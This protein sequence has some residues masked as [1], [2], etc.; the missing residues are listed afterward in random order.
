MGTFQVNI[1]IRNVISAVSDVLNT[2][3]IPEGCLT[4]NRLLSNTHMHVCA[5][6]L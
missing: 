1:K 5:L 3:S 6:A 4:E 2:D